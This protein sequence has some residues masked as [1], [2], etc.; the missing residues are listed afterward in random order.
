MAAQVSCRGLPGMLEGKAGYG[1][2]G[3]PQGTLRR[4]RGITGFA[5]PGLK[6]GTSRFT[7]VW[8]PKGSPHETSIC[9]GGKT[10]YGCQEGSDYLHLREEKARME[11]KRAPVWVW[12]LRDSLHETF[13]RVSGEMLE[14][15]L[16]GSLHGTTRRI[17]GES[18]VQTGSPHETSRC[19]RGKARC[20]CPEAPHIGLP[21]VSGGKAGY[22]HP[23]APLRC[24]RGAR[25]VWKPRGSPHGTTRGVKG[26]RLEWTPRGPWD[27]QSPQGRK[28]GM[29]NNRLLL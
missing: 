12:A 9:H 18:Q 16:K 22:R 1:H 28:L 13:R 29:D 26:E 21:D 20:G 10:G 15:I 23:K 3:L 8:T 25:W 4:T 27:F 14:C 6:Q 24:L 11:A 2:P 5:H 19:V 17:W 7:K